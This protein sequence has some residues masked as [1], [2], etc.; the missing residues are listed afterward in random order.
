MM[1]Y[2]VYG[3]RFNGD[4]VTGK[5]CIASCM[6]RSDAD[7]ILAKY[8]NGNIK[9]RVWLSIPDPLPKR[10][11]FYDGKSVAGGTFERGE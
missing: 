10:V 4:K 8:R 1:K 6:F 11:T 3:Q 7:T 9:G 2:K 5:V